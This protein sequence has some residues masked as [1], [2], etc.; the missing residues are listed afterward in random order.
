MKDEASWSHLDMICKGDTSCL[1]KFK[2]VLQVELPE[3]RLQLVTAISNNDLSEAASIVH[4]TKHKFSLMGM[5]SA[6][7]YAMVYEEALKNN[8]STGH[9]LFLTYLKELYDFLGL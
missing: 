6:Y 2:K 1:E 5:T 8:D 4:K 3:E 9:E 7:N